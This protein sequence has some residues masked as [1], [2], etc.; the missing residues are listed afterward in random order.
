MRV[1]RGDILARVRALEVDHDCALL[2]GRRAGHV[3]VYDANRSAGSSPEEGRER[4][5]D[6]RDTEVAGEL[7]AHVRGSR[8]ALYGML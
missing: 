7:G 2:P 3:N 5:V 8:V 4:T 1:F 6:V